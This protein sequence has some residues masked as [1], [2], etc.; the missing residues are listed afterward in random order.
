MQTG[1]HQ[2]RKPDGLIHIKQCSVPQVISE[3]Q[4]KTI[5]K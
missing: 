2:R 5:M 1:R 4:I 3:I